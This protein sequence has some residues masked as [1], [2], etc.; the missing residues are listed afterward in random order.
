LLTNGIGTSHLDWILV[1]LVTAESTEPGISIHS[2]YIARDRSS[3][4][5]Y[6]YIINSSAVSNGITLE[7]K[8][9]ESSM[10]M[11]ELDTVDN[12]YENMKHRET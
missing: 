11:E 6:K 1:I 2:R 3:V 9:I 5:A 8:Q 4:I 7:R 10:H 12:I